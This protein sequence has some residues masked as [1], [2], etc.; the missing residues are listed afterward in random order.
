LFGYNRLRPVSLYDRDYLGQQSVSIRRKV[1]EH[2]S[3]HISTDDVKQI[4]LVTSP[5]LLGYVFN[6][7]S[8]YFCLSPSGRLLAA[9]TEVNNTFG[10]KHVYVL[11]DN[12]QEKGAFPAR[13][14]ADKVFHV[15][16]FNNMEGT[17]RFTFADIREK[18]DICIDLHRQ[19]EHILRARL[20]GDPLPLTPFNHMK[21]VLRHPIWPHLTISRIYREAFKL[22]FIRK[23]DFFSKPVPRSPMTIG[24]LPPT[25]IQRYCMN[26]IFDHLAQSTRGRLRITLPDGSHV[27]FGEQDFQHHAHMTINDYRFFRGW[28]WARISAWVRP[29]C[30]MNG[31]PTIFPRFSAFLSVTANQ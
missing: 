12:L 14:Q 9:V 19:G 17:Y 31:I 26:L 3:A 21:T 24:R 16:P 18:L 11:S 7:A 30:S 23:L 29:S 13:F 22:F 5:R 15:S 28:C 27:E 4:I 2:V 8:F 25:T 6:P 1:L 20:Q 10:E